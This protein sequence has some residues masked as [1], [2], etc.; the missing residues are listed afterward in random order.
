MVGLDALLA[1]PLA[2]GL[3]QNHVQLAAMDAQ[4][5]I[6]IAGEF[7]ARLAI[8]ELPVAI[9]EHAFAIFDRDIAQAA[10][11][12]ER[13]EFAHGVRQQR[14]ADAERF[15]FRCAFEYLAGDSA[16]VEVQGQ[17]QAAMPPPITMIFICP[18]RAQR[19][20]PR[21][22]STLSER[23]PQLCVFEPLYDLPRGGFERRQ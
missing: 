4:F 8:N 13:A 18:H 5:R 22:F 2:R 9:E 6:F 16:L 19:S 3:E 11:Q 14:D 1:D 17:R 10:L 7:P 23:V 20:G 21:L 12:A 15:E